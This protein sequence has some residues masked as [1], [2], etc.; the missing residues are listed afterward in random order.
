MKLISTFH[1]IKAPWINKG[2]YVDYQ[3][4][5]IPGTDLVTL[6]GT[7]DYS[8]YND[9]VNESD[10]NAI[11]E[12]CVEIEPSIRNAEVSAKLSKNTE[13]TSDN[14]LDR[15]SMGGIAAS[16]LSRSC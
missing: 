3:T 7:R 10:A 13:S 12:R 9:R 15:V 1:Q 14:I 6:G 8:N 4:Y 5:I 2:I 11:M 16:S